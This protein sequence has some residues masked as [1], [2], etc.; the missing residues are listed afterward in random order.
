MSDRIFQPVRLLT[1]PKSISESMP[2]HALQSSFYS[3]VH[4]LSC[5]AIVPEDC[6]SL[7]TTAGRLQGSGQ[8]EE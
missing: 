1:H 2:Q 4:Q 7:A 8:P 5:V 3:I 6:P